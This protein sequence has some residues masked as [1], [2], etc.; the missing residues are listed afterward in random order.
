MPNVRARDGLSVVAHG[1]SAGTDH[2]TELRECLAAL[3]K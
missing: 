1:D 2:L 3:T